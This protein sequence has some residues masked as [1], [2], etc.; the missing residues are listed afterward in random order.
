MTLFQFDL[1][2]TRQNCKTA[3]LERK[4][5]REERE[6]HG[7][8]KILNQVDGILPVQQ[9]QHRKVTFNW[10]RRVFFI[11]LYGLPKTYQKHTIPSPNSTLDT[12]FFFES[13][14]FLPHTSLTLH[15]HLQSS[16]HF[17]PHTSPTLLLLSSHTSLTQYQSQSIPT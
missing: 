4:K 1:L 9:Q 2:T 13:S 3:K 6:I 14:H 17:L 5:R 8:K 11:S 16:T 7:V 15:P 12:F 10:F